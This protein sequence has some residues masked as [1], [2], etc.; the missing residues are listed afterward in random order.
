MILLHNGLLYGSTERATALAVEGNRIIAVGSDADVLNL[1]RPGTQQIDLEGAFVLP[2]LTDSHLHLD[3]YGQ[4][5]LM[6][7]CSAPTKAECLEQVYQRSLE[8]TNGS[9]IIGHGWNQNRWSSGFGNAHELDQFTPRNPV[10]LTDMSLHSAWVNTKAMELA[11]ITAATPDPAGGIIQR[12]EQGEPT[13]ILFE[14]AVNLVESII[15]SPTAAERRQNLLKAQEKLLGYG[16][17]SVHDFDRAPCFAALQQM[18]AD[19]SLVL[20]VLK[21]LPVEQL[22]EAIALGIGSGFGN[23]HLRIGSVKMFSDGALGP[24]TA[25]L[26][27]PYEGTTS[28]YGKLLLS[29]E[30]VYQTGARAVTSGLS[31]AVHAIGDR[32]NHEVLT[33]LKMLRLYEEEHCLP[34][35]RHRVEHMQLL[36]P[37]DLPMASA[38][39]ICASMQPVHLYM[40]MKTAETHWG[41]RSA[42]AFPIASLA[43]AGALIVFGSDAPVETPNPFWGLHAAVTRKE[44]SARPDQK[45]WYPVECVSLDTALKCYTHNPAIQ[46]GHE[47]FL[48]KLHS[49]FLAD[50]IV[51]KQNPFTLPA[52]E[53]HVLLPDRVMVSGNWVHQAA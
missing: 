2:G 7:D 34:R 32:A 40:D 35:L 29:A 16:V 13:G 28:N 31:L 43:A 4:S 3:L 20:R 26:L 27:S 44:R 51:L 6:V 41:K 9:W 53:L 5:L 14:A 38:L 17:T 33:G 8:V 23:R 11:G 19:G 10:F 49:G 22:D 15:P 25:A 36:D 45:S 21:S 24:Q 18:D 47:K 1:S 30:E 48:G 39:D 50:L 12:D 37:E 42:N 46:A 52:E